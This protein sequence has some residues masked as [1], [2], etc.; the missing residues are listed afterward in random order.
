VVVSGGDT[1]V[2]LFQLAA[3][4]EGSD[5][6]SCSAVAVDAGAGTTEVRV[7]CK[8]GPQSKS[9]SIRLSGTRIDADIVEDRRPSRRSEQVKACSRLVPGN[10]MIPEDPTVSESPAPDHACPD[11][12]VTRRVDGFLRRGKVEP[13][14][15]RMPLLLDVPALHLHVT[16]GKPMPDPPI[17]D[18]NSCE[19]AVVSDHGWAYLQCGIVENASYVRV[20]PLP[21]GV[22]VDRRGFGYWPRE[23]IPTPCDVRLVLHGLPCE[24]DCPSP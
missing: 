6:S 17:A 14:T 3:S 20:V 1:R 2:D 24:P 10:L 12:N 22:L 9:A 16:I 13:K 21:G 15:G 5:T 11:S 18:I 8:D 7:E 4:G 23:W 19:S